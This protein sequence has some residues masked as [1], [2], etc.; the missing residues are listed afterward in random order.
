MTCGSSRITTL[1]RK[2]SRARP[3]QIRLLSNH[4]V[5][6]VAA[7]MSTLENSKYRVYVALYPRHSHRVKY[8]WTLITEPETTAEGS[9]AVQSFAVEAANGWGSHLETGIIPA[10]FESMPTVRV[11]VDKVEVTNSTHLDDILKATLFPIH[12]INTLDFCWVKEALEK[13]K[14]YSLL[15]NGQ[16]MWDTVVT[17]AMEYYIKEEANPSRQNSK[18]IDLEKVPTYD[19]TG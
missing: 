15:E 6:T 4:S 16:P 7:P 12:E 8:C 17:V 5:A 14:A 2:H 18:H 11:R 10:P 1:T 19:L 9:T 3:Y 13:L